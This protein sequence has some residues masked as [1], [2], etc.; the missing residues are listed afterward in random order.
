M[1]LLSLPTL[2]PEAEGGKEAF[3][4]VVIV[5]GQCG[6]PSQ[7][8]EAELGQLVQCPLCRRSTVARTPEAV[9]PVARPV[10]PAEAPLS[11]DDAPQLPPVPHHRPAAPRPA[12][13]P[14]SPV[15]RAIFMALSLFLTLV[16]MGLVYGAFR[17]GNPDIPASAWKKFTPPDGR[18]SVDLPGDPEEE[19]IP[20]RGQSL[21]GKRFAVK[22]WF[23]R[24]EAVFG[25]IEFDAVRVKDD[26][27]DKAVFEFIGGEMERLSAKLTGEN[28]MQFVIKNREYRSRR[29]QADSPNGKVVVQIYCDPERLTTHIETTR[30]RKL[31]G[32]EAPW[33]GMLGSM[34]LPVEVTCET[35]IRVIDPGQRLRLYFAEARGKK[36][37]SETRWLDKFFN[38]FTPD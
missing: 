30:E 37:K 25:W 21:G 6:G 31:I 18:C 34:L 4:Y 32:E 29:F 28:T 9:L 10:A 19:D 7:V 35:R 13:P 14:R 38:S 5:C 12:P 23:E 15:R 1:E 33:V 17:Y 11:L 2:P 27:T 16:L 8:D 22:R 26:H 20:A 36:L 24:V 3:M